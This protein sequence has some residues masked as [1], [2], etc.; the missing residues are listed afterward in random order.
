MLFNHDLSTR[1]KIEYLRWWVSRI[2]L[3]TDA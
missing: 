3:V 1:V 2:H